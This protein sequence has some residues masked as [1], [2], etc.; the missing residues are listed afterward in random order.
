MIGFLKGS[1]TV[2]FFVG[3]CLI[4]FGLVFLLSNFGYI[5]HIDFEKIWP[6]VF[7][8]L[9]VSFLFKASMHAGNNNDQNNGLW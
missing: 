3:I 9:G 1:K 8:L 7:V 4:V 6:I 2:S 5:T